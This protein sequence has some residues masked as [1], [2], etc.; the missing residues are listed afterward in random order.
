MQI[1]IDVPSS[2]FAEAVT[3]RID[4]HSLDVAAACVYTC[5]SHFRALRRNRLGISMLF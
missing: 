5:H 1:N 3:E 4:R 2:T